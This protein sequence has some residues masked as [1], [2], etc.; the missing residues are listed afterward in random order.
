M[1]GSVVD[2]GSNGKQLAILAGEVLSSLLAKGDKAI[3]MAI[4]SGIVVAV[5]TQGAQAPT[6][7][8]ELMTVLQAA[9][10]ERLQKVSDGTDASSLHLALDFGRWIKL[11]TILLGQARN[12]FKATQ[13]KYEKEQEAEKRRQTMGLRSKAATAGRGGLL[14]PNGGGGGGGALPEGAG[15]GELGWPHG[16]Q[17][18]PL[19]GAP[20]LSADALGTQLALRRARMAGRGGVADGT[21]QVVEASAAPVG[22]EKAGGKRGGGTKAKGAVASRRSLARLAGLTPDG[23]AP[24]MQV[25]L[26]SDRPRPRTQHG[27]GLLFK[28]Q[29]ARDAVVADLEARIAAAELRR[30]VTSV[31]SAQRSPRSSP[32]E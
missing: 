15:I 10:R 24:G 17:G 16:A 1:G 2:E 22:A 18:G 19:H 12:Q 4:V 14:E 30:G 31:G 21:L 28:S 6:A 13:V 29:G 25:V 3:E 20:Q 23:S 5:R 26:E 8:P 9:A 32:Q 11:P 7:F 27:G